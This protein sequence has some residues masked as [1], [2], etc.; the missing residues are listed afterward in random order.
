MC[1][2]CCLFLLFECLLYCVDFYGSGK[3][4]AYKLNHRTRMFIPLHPISVG[5]SMCFRVCVF[6]FLFKSFIMSCSYI[7]ILIQPTNIT[8]INLTEISCKMSVSIIIRRFRNLM[9]ES[10][11]K[12]SHSKI[13]MLNLTNEMPKFVFF[14]LI[15]CS[16]KLYHLAIQ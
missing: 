9:S 14:H 3:T 1:E 16:R 2:I 8:L 12:L 5:F 10:I 15:Q 11:F 7:V 6:V 13:L 4:T